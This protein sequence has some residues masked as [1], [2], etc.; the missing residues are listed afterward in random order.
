MTRPILPPFLLLA[1][2]AA[3]AASGPDV[4]RRDSA[5]VAIVET[6]RARWGDSMPWTVDTAPLL[7]IGQE[8]GEEPYLFDRLAGALRLD[9][10]SIVAADGAT[11][12]LRHFDAN[13]TFIATAGRKGPGPGEF[14]SLQRIARCG[15]DAIWVDAGARLSIWGT[16]LRFRREVPVP[17]RI[18]SPLVCFGGARVVLVQDLQDPDADVPH[19]T[20]EYDSLQLFVRDSSGETRRELMRIPVNPHVIVMGDDGPQ[21]I[22][23]PFAPSTRLAANGRSMLVG[24]GQTFEIRIVDPTG[25]TIRI[26]RGPAADLRITDSVRAA[27]AA[28][29]LGEGQAGERELLRSGGV[30]MPAAFP[31]YTALLTDRVGNVWARRFSVPGS[32]QNR[33]GVFDP[34][35]RFLGHVALPNGL[36]P[37]EIGADYVLGKVQDALY[38]ERLLEFRLDKR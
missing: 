23:H 7:T 11:R 36:E 9:D 13:G 17:E 34:D 6:N 1:A 29:E 18:M 20:I 3:P 10:G 14:R 30:A 25:R 15:T 24:T 32:D 33:W 37:F 35:G 28:A 2:C 8:D 22:T 12:Q 27:Y 26:I 21:G 31:A 4:V 16:D 5:G 19:G 38:V